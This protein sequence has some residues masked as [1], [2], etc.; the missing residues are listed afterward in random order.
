MKTYIEMLIGLDYPEVLMPLEVRTTKADDAATAPFTTRTQFGWTVHRPLAWPRQQSTAYVHLTWTT[1]ERQVEFWKIEGAQLIGSDPG[2][3]V[4]DRRALDIMQSSIRKEEGHY[5][6]TIP[7]REDSALPD[8]RRLAEKRLASLAKKLEYDPTLKQRYTD[9]IKSLI[10]KGHAEKVPQHLHGKEGMKWYIP[11]HRVINPN[12]SKIW[13]VFDGAAKY[14]GVSL[15]DKVLQGLDLTN[16]LN[17][18]DAEN[19]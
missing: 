16:G 9:S 8:N 1:L 2:L 7:F 15:S 12:K 19:T 11:H 5:S 10:E 4:E 3:S 6:V 14:S 17:K 13:V 18:K